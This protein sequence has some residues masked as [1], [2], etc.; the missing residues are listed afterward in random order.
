MTYTNIN[1]YLIPKLISR[2][3]PV[4][5]LNRYAHLRERYLKEHQPV[6]YNQL[7]LE[8]RLGCHL[9]EVER[10]ARRD[11]ADS[12]RHMAIDSGV[13]EQLK[14]SDPMRWVKEMNAIRIAAEEQVLRDYVYSEEE[15][16]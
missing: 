3:E 5:G 14:R 15:S 13:D 7:L 6:L 12:I 11:L 16:T 1:G 8:D 10:C 4:G 2:D 9:N